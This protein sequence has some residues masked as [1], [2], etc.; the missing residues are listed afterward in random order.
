MPSDR[1]PPG[2]SAFHGLEWV[3][4][5]LTAVILAIPI[6]NF[7]YIWD[8]YVFLNEAS[9]FSLNSLSP[10]HKPLDPFWRPISRELYFAFIN[11]IGS[12]G[13]IAG[14]FVNLCVLVA[15]VYLL[16]RF[17]SMAVGRRGGLV[18]G[19]VFASLGSLPF[20][21]GWVSGIQDLFA[22]LFLLLA[23]TFRADGRD[24]AA[25]G[26]SACAL[27]SKETT[28]VL[29]P[30]VACLPWIEG[31][32]ARPRARDI[33]PY[34]V[35]GLA[36]ASIHPGINGLITH[37]FQGQEGLYIGG[38][39]FDGWV[40]HV[41]RYVLTVL[42]L[43]QW[44]YRLT[45]PAAMLLFLMAA[46]VVVWGGMRL[47][48]AF[49]EEGDERSAWPRGR[50]IT[51]G[52]YMT[53]MPLFF[54]SAIVRGWQPYYAG[55]SGIG[56]SVLAASTIMN[57]RP[58]ATTALLA[59]FILAGGLTRNQ[60]LEL[61]MTTERNFRPTAVA[62]GKV[63]RGFR[64]LHDNLPEDCRVVVSTEVR[65]VPGVYVHIYNVQALRQWYRNPSIQ[66]VRPECRRTRA[67]PE[68]FCLITPRL[69]VMEVD[70]ARFAIYPVSV[71]LDYSWGERAFRAYA[72]GLYASGGT[73]DAVA[74]LTR[75]PE[76]NGPLENCHHR[77]AAALLLAKGRPEEAKALL[78]PL[79]PL[80]RDYAI[81]NLAVFL[82]E[83]LPGAV[84]DGPAVRAFGFREDDRDVWLSLARWCV[85]NGYGDSGLRY[86]HRLLGLSP[87]DRD[88]AAL[89]PLLV[90]LHHKVIRSPQEDS[91][92]IE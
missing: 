36:W 85:A 72:L 82:A 17:V 89:E 52:V 55:I 78:A 92:P 90:K 50:V 15:V 61:D 49:S 73:D 26:M 76:V 33:A 24:G 19:L 87:K 63:E 91:P 71:P 81:E 37:R 20:L 12:L 67:R 79:V 70:P 40:T 32:V 66:A 80:P 8:D 59:T 42:N 6:L 23:L 14:H 4:P 18:A 51:S 54:T 9:S 62:L 75:M 25:L 5:V 1:V 35:L 77:L 58:A 21:V 83:P 2:D 68:I 69:D 84:I 88:A 29:V 11:G 10:W 53:L 31:K 38:V 30:V 27:L 60:A 86:I 45:S 47:S 74:M 64:A 65:G 13:S 3:V 41:A 34:A 44:D 43:P 7:G 57:W 56:L 39:K 48:A 28:A 16:V 46:V 22:M